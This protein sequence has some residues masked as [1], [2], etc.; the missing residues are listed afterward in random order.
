METRIEA[1][2]WKVKC[3]QL[4]VKRANINHAI[5]HNW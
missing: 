3:V 2:R 1:L 4:M 5:D